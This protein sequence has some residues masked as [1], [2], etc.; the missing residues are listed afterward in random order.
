M[1]VIQIQACEDLRLLTSEEDLAQTKQGMKELFTFMSLRG[2]SVNDP[3]LGHKGSTTPVVITIP[4]HLL[5]PVRSNDY[6]LN[7]IVREIFDETN[8]RCIALLYPDNEL[9][10]RLGSTLNITSPSQ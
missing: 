4:G 1:M 3:Y 2:P 8:R 5:E 9:G 6:T 7:L 10:R